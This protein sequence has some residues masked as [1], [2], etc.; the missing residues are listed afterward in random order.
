MNELRSGSQTELMDTPLHDS[1]SNSTGK[2]RLH[3]ELEMGL[4]FLK[5]RHRNLWGH[6]TKAKVYGKQVSSKS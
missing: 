4:S 5:S 3:R 1:H 6:E 2:K